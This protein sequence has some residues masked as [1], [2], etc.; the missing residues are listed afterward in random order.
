M[1]G[2]QWYIACLLDE[3]EKKN[4]LP[5]KILGRELVI[6]R[7]ESGKI[8]VAEDRCC[9]RNV[10]LS[11]GYIKGEQ[12]KCAYHGWEFNTEGKCVCIPSLPQG[13]QIP[14]TARIETYPVEI[15]HKCV[16]VY[17]GD[18]ALKE[19][20][21]IP[22]MTELDEYPLVY[23]YHFLDADLPLVAESLIDAYHINHVH[24]NSIKTF[25]GNLYGE[26]VNFNLD[27]QDTYMTG[28][29]IR[30][31][32]G[33]IWEKFYFG[34]DKEIDTHFGFWF[35]HTSK[36]D[37]RFKKRRMVIYEHFYQVDEHTISMCQITA[38]KKIFNGFPLFF[39]A[40]DFMLK[41]S[42]KIVEEDLV[43]LENNK[44]VKQRTGKRDLLI[45]SDEVTFEF[46]KL[47]NRNTNGHEGIAEEE[48]PE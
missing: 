45:K 11:L 39:F 3:L 37:I 40:K 33:S 36:L 24:R 41:K 27:V 17:I 22:P 16:W 4:P 26:K 31:N 15:R 14:R 20:A 9:H 35:P 28:S 30:H 8:S 29:Y 34:F 42:N 48:D 1:I 10:N 6:F 38:W 21:T 2:N 25:M 44:S 19:K 46:T 18:E 13:E 23:N 12:I 32:D 7:T 5:K 47:W 43:F